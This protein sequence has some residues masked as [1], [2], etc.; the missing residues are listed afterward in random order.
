MKL[1]IMQTS[2][3]LQLGRPCGDQG[4]FCPPMIRDKVGIFSDGMFEEERQSR[5]APAAGWIGPRLVVPAVPLPTQ[6]AATAP[7]S[8][9]KKAAFTIGGLALLALLL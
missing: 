8:A 6:Q 3:G 9:G 4:I 5:Y 1:A 7:M 2:Q